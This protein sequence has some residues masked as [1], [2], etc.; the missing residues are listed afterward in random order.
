MFVRI[1]SPPPST[2]PIV[3][4]SD[5][6]QV[7]M[8]QTAPSQEVHRA[9]YARSLSMIVPQK[10][11][12]GTARHDHYLSPA[13]KQQQSHNAESHSNTSWLFGEY[14]LLSD[15]G[16]NYSVQRQASLRSPGKQQQQQQNQQKQK[17]KQKQKQQQQQNRI[18]TIFLN[19]PL[20]SK[21]HT[22]PPSTPFSSLSTCSAPRTP[23]LIHDVRHELKQAFSASSNV[24]SSRVVHI[25]IVA[26]LR[27]SALADPVLNRFPPLFFLSSFSSQSR[28]MQQG[29]NG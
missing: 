1:S 17:Q 27:S 19:A 10:S 28:A 29:F 16:S 21:L 22:A 7:P 15:L 23:L 18:H 2:L 11:D 24:Q 5:A 20:T 9:S 4:L 3:D 12:A 8:K 25:P 6:M 13:Q 14:S 26:R